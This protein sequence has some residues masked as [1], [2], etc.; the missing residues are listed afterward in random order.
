M[1]VEIKKP[2]QG[3]TVRAISS[4]SA[5]HRLLICAALADKTTAI[6]CTDFSKD[7]DATADCLSAL[8]AD[9]RRTDDGFAVTPVH[10]DA[11][12]ARADGPVGESG[13]TFRFLLP[14]A[15][16][17][18]VETDFYPQGRLPHRPLSPL[19]EQLI[20]HGAVLSEQGSVPFRVGGRLTG[21]H[22]TI[23]AN[24][25]S[26]F[27]SGLLFALPLLP[28]DSEI[29][30]T[31]T[32]ESRAYVDMTRDAMRLFGV[33][34]SFERS[35]FSVR[36]GCGYRSPV[37]AAAEGDWSNAAFWLAMGALGREPVTVTGLNFR[38]L[39]GDRA[40]VDILR[41]FGARL[42]VNETDGSC[43]VYPSELTA[44]DI[45]AQNIPDLV[46]ILSLI[47]T[48]A[49]GKTRIFHASR[50]R[51]KESDR[52]KSVCVTL[53]ALGADIGETE[54]GL[55]IGRSALHGAVCDS[56]AD[57]RIA[58]TAAVASVCCDGALTV[59]RGEA[60]EK[61]YPAFWKDLVSLGA[62]VES[63]TEKRGS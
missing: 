63:N 48:Q 45:D 55:L 23:A 53:S 49:R 60:V 51:L 6:T 25:S 44:V 40:I 35:V 33:Q 30:V 11:L 46:P 32:F 27:I 61:S 3:G 34:T 1:Q 57:H 47:A 22:F 15:A 24:V 39:Q 13:S 2:P 14:V 20:A 4:K 52:L 58:M 29:E 16:A 42:S 5:A 17:L 19:Y 43:T 21:G 41:A 9:I 26:Q 56:F 54:D 28:E 38:S 18:G 31:G 8:S 50:L 10:R 62:L 36:G 7:I 59:T 37:R 12:P